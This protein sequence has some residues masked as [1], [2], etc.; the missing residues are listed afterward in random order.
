MDDFL[1]I[2]TG[3][4]IILTNIGSKY[5]QRD[6]PKSLDNIF[7]N[8]WFRRLIIFC[9]IFIST[10]DIK[11]S[12]LITILYILIFTTLLHEN[13]KA[14]ILPKKYLDFNK[15]GIVSE[16]ELIKARQLLK[17]HADIFSN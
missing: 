4:A 7:D 17:Q 8:I 2:F 15:D 10:R 6:L 12:I 1:K 14:C 11:I 3:C 5:I 16:D 9:L 13:S